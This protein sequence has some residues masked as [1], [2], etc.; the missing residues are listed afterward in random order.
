M[1]RKK[2][3][4]T[5]VVQPKKAKKM[6][7]DMNRAN[8]KKEYVAVN[9]KTGKHMTEKDRPRKKNWKKEY[10]R[11]SFRNH[12]GDYGSLLSYV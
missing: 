4:A 7:I 2:T 10:E 3:G 12:G 1:G 8:L 5:P 6:T 9:F 11:E